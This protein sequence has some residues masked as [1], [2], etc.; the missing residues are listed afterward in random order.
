M[1]E[2]GRMG[3]ALD[4]AMNPD[5]WERMVSAI[6]AAAG[7]ELRRLRTDRTAMS[8]IVEWTRPLLAVAGLVL[9]LSAAGLVWIEL[10]STSVST[11][12]VAE[13]VA[14]TVVAE[15]LVVDQS[16]TTEQLLASM[17]GVAR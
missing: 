8:L 12:A 5:R 9:V 1:K 11:P 2:E 14:P 13:V 3:P 6:T 15:W 17:E 10:G 16:P 4:P 7:A